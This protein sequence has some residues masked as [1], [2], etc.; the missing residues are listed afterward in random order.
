MRVVFPNFF[1]IFASEISTDIKNTSI[2]NL[3]VQ[4]FDFGGSTLEGSPGGG[5]LKV[6]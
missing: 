6:C 2:V 5:T 1:K 3:V 4:K